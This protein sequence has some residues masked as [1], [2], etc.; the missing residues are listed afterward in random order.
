ML[1]IDIY[2]CKEKDFHS[3]KSTVKHCWETVSKEMKKMGYDIST[4]KCCIKFQ[5]M[6][7]TYK[8]IKDHNNKPGNNTRKWKY[9][10]LMDKIF[11][12]KP[13]VEPLP[14]AGTSSTEET[15]EQSAK[16]RKLNMDTFL[17]NL[18]EEKRLKREADAKR[19]KE[20]ME[21]FDNLKNL[22]QKLVEK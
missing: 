4:R 12:K 2:T 13:W 11:N 21:Q 14:V 16:R 10:D 18:L 17:E 20:K 1:L 19:H 5:A 8:V 3:G 9:F 6:K 22:L 7:R 15:R